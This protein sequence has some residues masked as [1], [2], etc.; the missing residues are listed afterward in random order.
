GLPPADRRTSPGRWEWHRRHGRRPPAGRRPAAWPGGDS[1]GAGTSSASLQHKVHG[2][3][4]RVI[5][6]IA[7]G[8]DGTAASGALQRTRS[9]CGVRDGDVARFRLLRFPRDSAAVRKREVDPPN[10]WHPSWQGSADV[11]GC[12]STAIGRLLTEKVDRPRRVV[13]RLA[14]Q[15]GRVGE[16]AWLLAETPKPTALPSQGAGR[17]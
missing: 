11:F 6:G 5:A 14:Q 15:R 7:P 1:Q 13:S 2:K 3:R 12:E 8:P 10:E 9:R 4:E 16:R 17:L